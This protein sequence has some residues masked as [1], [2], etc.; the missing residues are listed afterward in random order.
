MKYIGVQNEYF[1]IQKVDHTNCHLLEETQK[2]VLKL[3]WFTSDDNRVTID[4]EHYVFNKNEIVCLTQFHKINH[5]HVN[6]VN[7]LR[8]NRQF[9]CVLDHDSEVGCKGILYYGAAKMPKLHAK[10]THLD[11]L[12]TAWHM[13]SLEF[14]MNDEL[15]QEMLQMMLKR[16]LILC[17]RMYRQQN[18]DEELSI[19]QHNL[20]REFNFLVEKHFRT[21]HTVVAYA[22]LLFKSPK[23]ISNTFKKLG[24]KTPL[25]FIQERITLEAKRLLYYTD[26]DISEIGYEIGFPDIQTFSRFFKKQTGKSPSDFRNT[27]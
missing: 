24:E 9:Y 22:E 12:Q 20:V 21:K 13:A 10:E 8:F 18:A 15:Q 14:E 11:I 17:T 25:Q 7:L 4:R 19:E 27:V 6:T 26:K 16:I 5:L 1:E 23:T 3:F 2:D